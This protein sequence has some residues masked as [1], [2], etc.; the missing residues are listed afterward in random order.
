LFK[1]ETVFDQVALLLREPMLN[2]FSL[3][4]RTRASPTTRALG[5]LDMASWGAGCVIHRDC[6]A[7]I[8]LWLRRRIC[9]GLLRFYPVVS[10]EEA[11]LVLTV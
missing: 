4:A 9:K 1:L 3:D 11:A 8:L 7:A 10:F 2:R 5:F 6:I